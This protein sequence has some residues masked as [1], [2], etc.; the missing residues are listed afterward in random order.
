[1]RR[2]R[3]ALGL[4]PY[5][6]GLVDSAAKLT[7]IA[8]SSLL[9]SWLGRTYNRSRSRQSAGICAMS[10]VRR[11]LL[12]LMIMVALMGGTAQAE[13][14]D[15]GKSGAKLFAANCAHCHRSPR[16][17]AKELDAVTLP[18]TALHKRLCLGAGSYR[19]ST[20]GRYSHQVSAYRP[21]HAATGDEYI[22]AGATSTSAGATPLGMAI[23]ADL[24]VVCP[25]NTAAANLSG[26]PDRRHCCRRR[27]V[28][29]MQKKGAHEGGKQAGQRQRPAYCRARGHQLP[30]SDHP[31]RYSGASRNRHFEHAIRAR[32]QCCRTRNTPQGKMRGDRRSRSGP[33]R[34]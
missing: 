2:R 25:F 14:L 15:Q 3:P 24:H 22:G 32:W 13:D 16:G 18:A 28:R 19:L 6:T 23:R 33:N 31:E 5:L 11:G 9:V 17:L 1:M 7:P 34:T 26:H 8:L 20:V 10:V 30:L 12:S 27:S 29:D 21:Q 4:S